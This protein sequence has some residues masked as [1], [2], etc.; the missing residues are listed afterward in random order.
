MAQPPAYL[1]SVATARP[2]AELDGRPSAYVPM[3]T[4]TAAPLPEL[5]GGG[6]MAVPQEYPQHTFVPQTVDATHVACA[7]DRSANDGSSNG[8][9]TNGLSANTALGNV[10]YTGSSPRRAAAAAASRQRCPCGNARRCCNAAT[11]PARQVVTESLAIAQGGA[12]A[13]GAEEAVAGVAGSGAEETGGQLKKRELS[14]RG[15]RWVE[16]RQW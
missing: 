6:Q 16:G 8:R 11:A 14:D 15:S 10:R 3:A 2:E 13:G 5:D 4:A 12:C 1:S 7:N 9:S